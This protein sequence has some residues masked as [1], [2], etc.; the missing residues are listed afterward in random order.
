MPIRLTGRG[1]TRNEVAALVGDREHDDLLVADPVRDRVERA[2]YEVAVD[3]ELR[4][5]P[6]RPRGWKHRDGSLCL[7]DGRDEVVAGVW[8]ELVHAAA[9]S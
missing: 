9:A 2:G 7:L 1:G 5:G 4:A 8:A 6:R 3:T